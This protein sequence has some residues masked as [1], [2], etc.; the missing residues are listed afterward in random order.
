MK[1]N[2]NISSRCCVVKFDCAVRSEYATYILLRD[3][4]SNEY[5]I[6]NIA[7][8]G[9]RNEIHIYNSRRNREFYFGKVTASCLISSISVS[10][11]A[12]SILFCNALHTSCTFE[13]GFDQQLP[14]TKPYASRD[15]FHFAFLLFFPPSLGPLIL[16]DR[17]LNYFPDPLE[18]H[19]SVFSMHI[20]AR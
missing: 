9:T 4:Y 16:R 13:R 17:F 11:T 14:Y 1:I 2:I 5:I 15:A 3:A 19:Q 6:V 12:V 18:E 8:G 7:T 20:N 10:L